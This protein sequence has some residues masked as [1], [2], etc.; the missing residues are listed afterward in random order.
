MHEKHQPI[1]EDKLH[2]AYGKTWTSRESAEEAA[3]L[4]CKYAEIV[5]KCCEN[6]NLVRERRFWD[7][8]IINREFYLQITVFDMN[9]NE[10]F[11]LA[12]L[13]ALLKG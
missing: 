1:L 9:K 4:T 10:E 13:S 3:K 6:E 5:M 2:A 11:D 7:F 8:C 12:I